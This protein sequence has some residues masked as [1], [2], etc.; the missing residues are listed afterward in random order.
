MIEV[1]Q[2]LPPRDWCANWLSAASRVRGE[3]CWIKRGKGMSTET[4]FSARAKVSLFVPSGWM[5]EL[6]SDRDITVDFTVAIDESP[7]G[8]EG[9]RI[10]AVGWSGYSFVVTKEEDENHYH[11]GSL[12]VDWDKM[13]VSVQKGTGWCGPSS[14]DIVLLDDFS[15]NYE[16]SGITFAGF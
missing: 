2:V 8:L 6:E 3:P 10:E 9:Y 5:D 15:V 4:L 12:S 11:A 13:P 7:Y 14:I 16:Q 1:S